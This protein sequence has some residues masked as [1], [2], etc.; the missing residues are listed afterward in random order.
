MDQGPLSGFRI[1]EFAGLGPVPFCGMILSDL[2]ADIIRID[3]PGAKDSGPTYVTARGR[4]SIRLDLKRPEAIEA[5]LT[6]IERADAL[7]EGFRPGVMERFGLGP[8]VALQRN[9]RLVYGRVTGWGQTGPLA[10]AAAHDINYIAVTGALHAIGTAERP[11]PP[12][13]L[14]GDTGGS[15]LYLA[16]GLLAGMLHARATG[17]G[18]VV[19]AAMVDGAASLMAMVYGM[20]AAGV[21]KDERESNF[22]DGGA[23]F[24]R[25]YR[26]ADGEWISI[27]SFEP[28]FYLLLIEKTGFHDPD[29]PNR[30]NRNV[31]P[32]LREK[33]AELIATKSRAEWCALLEGTD[34]CFAPVLSLEEAPAYPHNV[35]RQIFVE[36]DGVVQPAP[37]P[38]FSATPGAIQRSPPDAGAHNREALSD[39]GFSDGEIDG[40]VERGALL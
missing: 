2:G 30:M 40:L 32:E 36:R 1:V 8:D 4:R 14:V 27:A 7:Y 33:M 16:I 20:K 28:Q 31:W 26:C 23:H 34:V 22:A 29:I 9:P 3:R 10:Q 38:R 19:D 39:W 5:C 25:A 12:L 21:W 18:Q 37:A 17:T 13:H 15:A 24:Y 35:A 6:L 11:I